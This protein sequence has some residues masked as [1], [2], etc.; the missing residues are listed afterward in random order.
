MKTL[1][2]VLIKELARSRSGA[3]MLTLLSACTLIGCSTPM[4]TPGQPQEGGAQL[5]G[6]A[7]SPLADLNLVKSTIPDVLRHARETPY[8]LPSTC[9][10][11]QSQLNALNAVLGT[12]LDS[13]RAEGEPDWFGKA[14]ATRGEAA[15]GGLRSATEGLLPFRSWIRKLTGAESHSNE[16]KAALAAGLA[17]RAFL[18]GWAD[19]KG[20]PVAPPKPPAHPASSAH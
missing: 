16:V 19:A 14:G 15:V 6:A 5:A 9:P 10:D 4:A 2:V 12:D 11:A 17:R 13:P 20:C 3:A 7:T 18:R 8:A 1:R